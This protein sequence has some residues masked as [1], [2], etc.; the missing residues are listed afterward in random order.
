M[1][2]RF[3]KTDVILI[4]AIMPDTRSAVPSMFSVSGRKVSQHEIQNDCFLECFCSSKVQRWICKDIRPSVHVLRL[5]GSTKVRK[6]S[7]GKWEFFTIKYNAQT[8]L[9]IPMHRS[10]R[11]Q[12]DTHAILLPH[13]SQHYKQTCNNPFLCSVSPWTLEQFQSSAVRPLLSFQIKGSCSRSVGRVFR[14]KLNS[15]CSVPFNF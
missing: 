12:C 4:F 2:I 1:Q 9:A 8:T 3:D 6:W 15:N 7:Y 5:P 14:I 13:M 10:I 11:H